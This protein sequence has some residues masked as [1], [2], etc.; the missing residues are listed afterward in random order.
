MD[1]S[2]VISLVSYT[3]S[4]DAY[5][6]WQKAKTARDV[7]C[8]VESVTRDEF[9]EGG[10]NGFNPQ[11]RITMFSYDYQGEEEVE[12][13]GVSY[14]VYRTYRAKTDIIE[15]YVEKKGGVNKNEEDAAGSA[16]V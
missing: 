8:A 11:F 15:L 4:Q 13:N 6:V 12:Y 16:S 9:F 1:R 10:R 5:G 7:F 3:L 14:G 2:D